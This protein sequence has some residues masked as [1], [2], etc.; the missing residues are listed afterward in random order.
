MFEFE[1]QLL[2]VDIYKLC[3]LFGL[4][5]LG[6]MVYGCYFGFVNVVWVDGYVSCEMV[7]FEE[8]NFQ[9]VVENFGDLYEG[10]LLSNVWWDGGIWQF[11]NFQV[12]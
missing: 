10:N 5:F 6:G 7:C 9:D 11:V 12:R 1:L 3:G 8:F 2:V 4:D